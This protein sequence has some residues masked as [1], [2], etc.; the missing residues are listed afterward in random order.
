MGGGVDNLKRRQNYGKEGDGVYVT[1]KRKNGIRKG[2]CFYRK[3]NGDNKGRVW[4]V[5]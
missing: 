1:S 2:K 5:V 3:K 4:G